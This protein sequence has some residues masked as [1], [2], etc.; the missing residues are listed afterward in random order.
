MSHRAVNAVRA[1]LRITGAAKI[2][3][4][5]LLIDQVS[6]I[7][8]FG[9]VFVGVRVH[10]IALGGPTTAPFCRLPRGSHPA[11][12]DEVGHS[13]AD[14]VSFGYPC[15]SAEISPRLSDGEVRKFLAPDPGE[16]RG[17]WA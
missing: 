8:I 9:S 4:T 10:V 15:L 11:E 3:R 17:W 2:A 16:N 5:R 6:H 7:G 14:V 12:V 1:R 13:L